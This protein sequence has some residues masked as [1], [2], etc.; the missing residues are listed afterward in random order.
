MFSLGKRIKNAEKR[1]RV[2]LTLLPLFYIHDICN[3]KFHL[4]KLKNMPDYSQLPE[5][6]IIRTNYHLK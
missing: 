5:L 6:K 2:L 1:L 3:V 4:Q